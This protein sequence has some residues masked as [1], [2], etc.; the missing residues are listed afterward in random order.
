M[1]EKRVGW[2]VF[3]KAASMV[4]DSGD[5]SVDL[6]AVVMVDRRVA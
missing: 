6:T 2:M 4:A 3:W 1:V 5:H